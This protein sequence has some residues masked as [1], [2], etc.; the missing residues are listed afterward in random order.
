MLLLDHESRFFHCNLESDL[1]G[2]SL[3][4][5]QAE[6]KPHG[7]K[8]NC[9]VKNHM[10][11]CADLASHSIPSL[12]LF[13]NSPLSLV[14]YFKPQQASAPQTTSHSGAA[15]ASRGLQRPLSLVLY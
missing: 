13:L 4:T 7:I 1:S 5:R 6:A 12:P 9:D 10:V 11:V 14:G 2:L 8:T 15:A 3:P